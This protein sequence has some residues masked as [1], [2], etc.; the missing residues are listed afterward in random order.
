MISA[1]VIYSIAKFT[2]ELLVSGKITVSQFY[3]PF[4]LF[5]A[6]VTA[7][8]ALRQFGVANKTSK[9]DFIYKFTQNFFG[10]KVTTRLI[11]LFDCNL[12]EFDKKVTYDKVNNKD[13]DYPF[14]KL[15]SDSMI[16]ERT[17]LTGD[18]LKELRDLKDLKNKYSGYEID[19]NLLGYF[20]DIAGFIDRGILDFE[21]AYEGFD[22]YIETIWENREIKKY[23]DSERAR[24][25]N[26]VWSGFEDIYN[27][28]KTHN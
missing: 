22:L 23:I 26:D 19:D 10:N 25:G 14:F 2:Y 4:G 3:T 24:Y 7:W 6:A 17:G 15:V 20:E 8:I 21:H 27:R 5:I 12:L 9:A 16:T 11:M 13:I 18:E 1:D 28:M